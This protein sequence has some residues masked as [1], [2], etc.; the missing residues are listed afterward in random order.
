MRN[1]WPQ[2]AMVETDVEPTQVNPSSEIKG[3]DL[4]EIDDVSG[5]HLW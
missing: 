2:K 3:V 1:P 5:L 4:S